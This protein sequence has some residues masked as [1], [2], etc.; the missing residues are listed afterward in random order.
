MAFGE[1]AAMV[2]AALAG[3][4]VT[5]LELADCQFEFGPLIE[6]RLRIGRDGRVV[7][8]GD[9]LPEAKI[10]EIDLPVWTGKQVVGRFRM[11]LRPGALPDRERLV[12]AVGIADQ[13]GAALAGGPNRNPAA[14]PP[15]RLRL[16]R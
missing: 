15:R 5:R 2:V 7:G 4:L 8:L 6:D 9:R 3:E 14:S 1:D 10:A 13:A 12:A 11:A 16:I